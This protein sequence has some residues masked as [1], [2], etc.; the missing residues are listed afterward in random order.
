MR[1][2][3]DENV[4]AR[5]ADVLR[6]A[7]H[8]VATVAEQGLHGAE[9]EALLAVCVGESRALV[10]LDLDFA[11]PFRYPPEKTRGLV[12][13]RGATNRFSTMRAIAHTL[14]H[15]LATESPNGQLWIVE[16]GRLPMHEEGA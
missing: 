5:L 2:K 14:V 6:G 8:D 16:V 13:L 12:V 7:G 10:T 15:A 9:D 1:L 3:L 11:D 4:D